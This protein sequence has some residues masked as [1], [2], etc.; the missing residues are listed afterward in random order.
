MDCPADLELFWIKM[1]RKL[2][3]KGNININFMS[4]CFFHI[5][6]YES[7]LKHNEAILSELMANNSSLKMSRRGNESYFDMQFNDYT[8]IPKLFKKM[9]AIAMKE[10]KE[11]K[12]SW[13]LSWQDYA[14][15]RPLDEKLDRIKGFTFV[16]YEILNED[17]IDRTLRLMFKK[18]L[19]DKVEIKEDICFEQMYTE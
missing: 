19:E 2:G 9:L 16:N 1:F 12:G 4:G 8:I 11:C 6:C 17:S 3:I 18:E 15:V 7:D 13:D 14:N 10:E 5:K